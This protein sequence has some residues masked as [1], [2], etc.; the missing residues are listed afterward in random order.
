VQSRDL[1]ARR[2][3]VNAP[4]E[5]LQDVVRGERVDV[6]AG[7]QHD[8]ADH[9]QRV[10]PVAATQPAFG[11]GFLQAGELVG[12]HDLPDPVEHPFRPVGGQEVIAGQD[13]PAYQQAAQPRDV[14]LPLGDRLAGIAR[15]QRVDP[16][17]VP[18]GAGHRPPVLPALAGMG[19]QPVQDRGGSLQPHGAVHC[20][21]RPVRHPGQQR[22][23]RA[24]G[25]AVHR[26][27]PVLLQQPLIGGER[28]A[29]SAGPG[30]G[31]CRGHCGVPP[32]R[33]DRS[34]AS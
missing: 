9:P 23:D 19:E 22:E 6:G 1:P 20:P 32:N 10:V 8:L 34:P 33:T 31:G 27:G 18:V 17:G 29:A 25:Q 24:G 15:G 2:V 5:Q 28:A 4:R 21:G 11:G 7:M 14:L 26:A 3:G 13:G 16:A 30:L 12:P